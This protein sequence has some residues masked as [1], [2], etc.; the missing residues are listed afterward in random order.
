[1]EIRIES[2]SILDHVPIPNYQASRSSQSDPGIPSV[3]LLTQ[4]LRQYSDHRRSNVRFG[5][6]ESWRLS[7][8]NRRH[9]ASAHF[10][11]PRSEFF[12]ASL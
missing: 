8:Q 9:Q 2:I 11:L 6:D 12:S 3:T 7:G 1:M 5:T 10:Q 4:Y